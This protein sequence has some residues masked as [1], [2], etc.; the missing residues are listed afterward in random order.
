MQTTPVVRHCLQPGVSKIN[1]V[2]CMLTIQELALMLV[3]VRGWCATRAVRREDCSP[4]M[5]VMGWMFW[6][7]SFSASRSS[8]PASTTTDVV[9]SPTSASCVFEI[10]AP[11]CT[12]QIHSAER[13]RSSLPPPKT[14]KAVWR[15][16]LTQSALKRGRD[17]C[18]MKTGGTAL[19]HVHLEHAVSS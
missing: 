10:S 4:E 2:S 12:H 15:A 16:P 13:Q 6:L 11:P 17:P 3:P 8:S 1:T 9:P 19:L 14:A 7:T 5:M 18:C